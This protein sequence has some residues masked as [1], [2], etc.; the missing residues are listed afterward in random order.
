MTNNLRKLN[1]FRR[2]L[3]HVAYLEGLLIR[4][5]QFG[6]LNELIFMSTFRYNYLD[7]TVGIVLIPGSVGGETDNLHTHA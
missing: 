3:Q 6:E 1:R 7:H 2:V 5:V 4:V